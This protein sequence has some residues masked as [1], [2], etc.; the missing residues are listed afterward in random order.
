MATPKTPHLSSKELASDYGW[1]MATLNSIPD[2]KKLFKRAVAK[3]Y[4][5][6]RFIAE[7][8]NTK[9]Y[10]NSSES[11]RKFLVLQTADPSQ[12]VAQ[13]KQV[14]ASL[15]DQYSQATGQVPRF[16]PPTIK[17]GKVVPGSG[18]LYNRALSSM[19]MGLNDAQIKDL[20]FASVD[21]S[22]RIAADTLGGTASGQVQSLR[23]QASALGVQPSNDWYGE[24]LGKIELGNDTADSS[25]EQLKALAKQRYSAFADQI[26]GGATMQDISEGY[27]QSMAKVLEVN[28]ASVDVFDPKIQDALTKRND[29]GADAPQSITDFEKDLRTDDRWQYTQNAKETLLNQGKNVLQ[30]FGLSG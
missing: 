2:L 24:Q 7:M 6:E 11:Q 10:K 28:P 23:A 15:N 14:M 29:Q 1:A 19:Q 18:F 3:Q 12:Y 25:L 27:K 16:D 8:R 5:P 20:L 22:Q 9:W 26:D 21:W 30:S 17:N 4:T 13:M